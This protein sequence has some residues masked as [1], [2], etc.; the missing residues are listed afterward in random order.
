MFEKERLRWEA[1]LQRMHTTL[2]ARNEYIT[3]LEDKLKSLQRTV[4]KFNWCELITQF[5]SMKRFK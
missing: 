5:N 2:D 3:G 4:F 1:M